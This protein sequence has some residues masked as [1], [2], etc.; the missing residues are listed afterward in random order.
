MITHDSGITIPEFTAEERKMLAEKMDM[1][2]AIT[3]EDAISY[4]PRSKKD[5]AGRTWRIGENAGKVVRQLF[6]LWEGKGEAGDGSIHKTKREMMAETRLTERKLRDAVAVLRSEGLLETWGGY[7]NDRRQTTFYLLN[8][9]ECFKVAAAS[10]IGTVEGRLEHERN[11]KHRARL[12][13]KLAGL[14]ATLSDLELRFTERVETATEVDAEREPV[15]IE[16]EHIEEDGYEDGDVP[17]LTDEDAPEVEPEP[18][19]LPDNLTDYPPQVDSPTESMCQGT[20]DKLSPLHETTT[21][22]DS[23]GSVESSFNNS[24]STGGVVADAPPAGGE[25]GNH[26]PDPTTS[27]PPAEDSPDGRG[28][29][30]G[31]STY[32]PETTRPMP[33]REAWAMYER[34]EVSLLDLEELCRPTS[35]EVA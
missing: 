11:R 6:K 23:R 26:E 12:E 35:K 21:R 14:R 1:L 34:G 13:E 32:P 30:E 19:W 28:T 27:T 5:A 15:E 16:G 33:A 20:H 29:E 17:S 22:D 31:L 7:R 25:D 2:D 24:D 8:L 18:E 10:E 9:W 3:L 4:A